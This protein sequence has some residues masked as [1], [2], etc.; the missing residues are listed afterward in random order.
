MANPLNIKSFFKFL[1][2]NKLYTTINIFGLSVSLM[3]VIVVALYA[4]KEMSVDSWHSKKDRIYVLG[5]EDYTG[6]SYGIQPYLLERYPEIEKMAAVGIDSQVQLTIN[7]EKLVA[8]VLYADSTFFDL[9]DFRVIDGNGRDILSGTSQAM[10]SRSFARRMFRDKDPVGTVMDIENYMTVSVAGIMEDIKNSVIPESDIIVSTLNMPKIDPLHT[11]LNNVGNVAQFILVKEG[12]DLVSKKDEMAEYFKTFFWIYRDD[13]SAEVTLTPLEDIYFSELDPGAGLVSGDKSIVVMLSV[14]SLLIL[15]F[16]VLN[17]INLT[18]AQTGFRAKE[19][20]TRKFMGASP[21]EIFARFITESIL[22]CAAAFA[23]GLL[24]AGAFQNMIGSF[25]QSRIDVWGSITWGTAGVFVLFVIILGTVAG[26]IPAMHITRYNAIDVVKGTFRQRSKMVFSKVFI[27]FQ[28]VITIVL[29]GC[30]ITT[31]LQVKHLMNVPLGYNTENII[32]ADIWMIQDNGSRNSF[33]NEVENLSGVKRV[34]MTNGYPLYGGNNNTVT[35]DDGK[36]VAF[37]IFEA[38]SVFFD[39]MGLKIINDNRVASDYGYWVNERLFRELGLQENA[40]YFDFGEKKP[41]I[42][43]V[44][45]D[46][47]LWNALSKEE[48]VIIARTLPRGSTP[49]WGL[50]IE[51][52][53]DKIATLNEIKDLYKTMFERELEAMYTEDEL[54]E[55][56]EEQ[57]RLYSMIMMFTVIAV[58][59]SMLGLLAMSTYYI[60]QRSGEIAIRKVFGSTRKEVFSRLVRNF[61]KLVVIAFV[62]A[63]PIIW[64]LMRQWLSQFPYRINLS[65]LIFLAAGAFSLAIAAVTVMWQSAKASNENPVDSL[66]KE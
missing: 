37:Q 35:Y 26:I 1:G 12:A 63:V 42:F 51:V 30:S 41:L 24:L 13:W 8:D 4:Y 5:D 54:Y 40:E 29:L 11:G 38:D 25:L 55:S 2:R 23:I 6:S 39:M 21:R 50:L 64:Y 18:V 22:M 62:I 61:L 52:Q 3:F 53:G 46:F 57:R 33:V 43:G 19:M 16:A 28:N 32:F 17:Y 60:Q 59:I 15:I 44:I 20:A 65:P 10:L 56:Y 27:V 14:I 47:K 58:L 9:F 31:M 49:F 7:G 36:Q 45:E 34:S 48:R 66:H